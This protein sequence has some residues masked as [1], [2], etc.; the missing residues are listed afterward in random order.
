MVPVGRAA[1]A[2]EYE[3]CISRDARGDPAR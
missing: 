1:D 2:M 3:V